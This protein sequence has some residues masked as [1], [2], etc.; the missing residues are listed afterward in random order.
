[1]RRRLTSARRCVITYGSFAAGETATNRPAMT[2]HSQRTTQ[3][4]FT[5]KMICLMSAKTASALLWS[6]GSVEAGA[7]E[8]KRTRTNS[9]NQLIESLTSI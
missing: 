3:G 6:T 4:L 8:A 7:A 9:C 1:M 5:Y 2:P